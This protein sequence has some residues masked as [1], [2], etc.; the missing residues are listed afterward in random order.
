MSFV[1]LSEWSVAYRSL[2]IKVTDFAK[3]VLG[4]NKPDN[5][6]IDRVNLTWVKQI[7]T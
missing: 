4:K 6:S 1:P 3:V 7:V 5:F 2:S